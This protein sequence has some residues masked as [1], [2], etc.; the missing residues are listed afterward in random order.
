M[1]KL[2][3]RAA[4]KVRVG[5]V[6]KGV[7]SGKIPNEEGRSVTESAI[8]DVHHVYKMMIKDQ[9]MIRARKLK[10]MVYS[11]F[12]TQFRFAEKL[13][14]VQLVRKE[15]LLFPPPTGHLYTFKVHDGNIGEISKRHIYKLTPL[16]EQDEL[17]WTNLTQAYIQHWVAPQK[18]PVYTVVEKVFKM[19]AIPYVKTLTNF[20]N[21]LI[22]G[23]TRAQAIIYSSPVGDWSMYF[24][25]RAKVSHNNEYDR[26]KE[27]ANTLSEQLYENQVDRAIANLAD[28]IVTLEKIHENVGSFTEEKTESAETPAE[29]TEGVEESELDAIKSKLHGLLNSD[30]KSASIEKLRYAIE[31]IDPDKYFNVEEVEAAIDE[32][33][34][35]TRAGLTPEEYGEDRQ[36]AFDEIG[37]AIDGI[38]DNENGE[39]SESEDESDEDNDSE[40]SEESDEEE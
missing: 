6:I 34:S 36:E 21:K 29:A 18:A 20:R 9:N 2:R 37:N 4:S 31:G 16:G 35:I 1:P 24:E 28:M 3:G 14:L 7:L 40:N 26:L 10:P 23:V 22:S 30:K 19:S 5:M 32:Y 33:E 12:I 8:V 25:K 15:D 39:E 11:S 38:T 13:N 17:S 27:M